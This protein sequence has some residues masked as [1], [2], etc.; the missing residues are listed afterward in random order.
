MLL[1]FIDQLEQLNQTVIGFVRI[2]FIIKSSLSTFL[3]G[4]VYR[5]GNCQLKKQVYGFENKSYNYFNL[6]LNHNL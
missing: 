6:Q 3:F 2:I 5:V 4:V 1:L